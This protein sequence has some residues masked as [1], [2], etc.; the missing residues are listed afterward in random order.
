M[1]VNDM[2]N[3]SCIID[4]WKHRTLSVRVPAVIHVMEL[5]RSE[6][7]DGLA[8]ILEKGNPGAQ[9]CE[10]WLPKAKVKP[11]TRGALS[12]AK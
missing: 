11:R 5:L 8:R 10:M 7:R 6:G 1:A 3:V 2:R 12:Q 9:A 4:V